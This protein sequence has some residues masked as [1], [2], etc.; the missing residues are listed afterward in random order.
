M[1]LCFKGSYYEQQFLMRKMLFPVRKPIL[2]RTLYFW[3]ALGPKIIFDVFQ[4]RKNIP[5]WTVHTNDVWSQWNTEVFMT[6]KVWCDAGL[7]DN[8]ES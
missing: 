6:E 5:E 7:F 4:F 2:C 3:S 8:R 1:Q